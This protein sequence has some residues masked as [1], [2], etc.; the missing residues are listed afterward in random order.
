MILNKQKRLQVSEQNRFSTRNIIKPSS[1]FSTKY[2]NNEQTLPSIST[3]VFCLPFDLQ[4]GG[5]G[6]VCGIP[7]SHLPP[8]FLS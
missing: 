4:E 5:G 6:T 2:K 8:I 7:C 1:N 3:D